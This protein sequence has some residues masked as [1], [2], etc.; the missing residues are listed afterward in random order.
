MTTQNIKS[1]DRKSV[2]L[3]IEI[4][5]S[6]RAILV[7]VSWDMQRKSWPDG[8]E[9]RINYPENFVYLNNT[10]YTDAIYAGFN[11]ADDGWGVLLM[12]MAVDESIT[13]LGKGQTAEFWWELD[14]SFSE[15]PS[16]L[17]DVIEIKTSIVPMAETNK[18]HFDYRSLY[19]THSVVAA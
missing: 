7:N 12:G 19:N 11:N 6:D 3:A 14:G 18:S 17:A 2:E 5:N 10:D 9:E 1:E 16:E 15:A 13:I 8:Y 4:P